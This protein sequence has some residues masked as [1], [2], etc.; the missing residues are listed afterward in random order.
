MMIFTFYTDEVTGSVA[1]STSTYDP[2]N[3]LA[4]NVDYYYEDPAPD[5]SDKTVEIVTDINWWKNFYTLANLLQAER[6][7]RRLARV[8]RLTVKWFQNGRVRS[9]PCFHKF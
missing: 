4:K 2:V 7:V 6:V 5:K 3:Q 8:T 1:Y 9:P